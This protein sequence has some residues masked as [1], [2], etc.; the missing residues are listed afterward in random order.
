[1]SELGFQ[2]AEVFF[3][4]HSLRKYQYFNGSLSLGVENPKPPLWSA[5]HCIDLWVITAY[6]G[7]RYAL[8]P[9]AG[10]LNGCMSLCTISYKYPSS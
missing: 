9:V 6:C 4:E 2:I 10:T 8:I 1:M 7:L 3:L 5:S